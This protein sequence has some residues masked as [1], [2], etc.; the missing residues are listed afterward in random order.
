MQFIFSMG[1]DGDI[2]QLCKD[3]QLMKIK[4]WLDNTE[5]DLNQGDD[6]WFTP[7][8]WASRN[9]RI[10]VVELLISRGNRFDWVMWPGFNVIL[11]A[12]VSA[13]N[14]GDDTPLHNAAQ[15]GQLS[16]IKSLVKNKAQ[17][18]AQNE[19]GNSPLHYAC[20]NNHAEVSQYL[21]MTNNVSVHVK[22]HLKMFNFSAKWGSCISVQ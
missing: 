12:R 22:C 14:R 19:H 3:G 18:N 10:E 15:C 16:V 9:G 2:F 20:F 13:K 5:N 1:I 21:G 7:L 6:H 17:V 8:H 11:G 4:Q